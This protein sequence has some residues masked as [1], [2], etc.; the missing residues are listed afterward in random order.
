MMYVVAVVGEWETSNKDFEMYL[1]Q[2]FT[3]DVPY[4]SVIYRKFGRC[5][6][7]IFKQIPL[8]N[9]GEIIIVTRDRISCRNG[10]K[11]SY[12]KQFFFVLFSAVYL[13]FSF[14]FAPEC[15]QRLWI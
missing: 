3:L 4:Q 13:R 1:A 2:N 5:M 15:F 9:I 7:E 10:L 6:V 11:N 12:E 8:Q 14:L